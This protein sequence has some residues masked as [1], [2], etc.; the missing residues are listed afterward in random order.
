MNKPTIE[1]RAEV[2][3]E[4]L[5]PYLDHFGRD[6]L[7]GFYL[8]WTESN[9]G[10]RKMRFEMQKVFDIKRRLATW[11]KKENERKFRSGFDKIHNDSAEASALIRAKY[12]TGNQIA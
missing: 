1:Q 6:T 12:G 5:R 3:K 10:G 11:K 8:Y 7:N 9:E 2:F 4:K